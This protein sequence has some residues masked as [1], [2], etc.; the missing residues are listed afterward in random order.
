MSVLSKLK[1]LFHICDHQWVEV[2]RTKVY[3]YFS[4][5]RASGGIPDEVKIV[6]ELRC[7]QC[8]GHKSQEN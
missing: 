1:K 2:N 6:I 5:P 7:S 8:G 3:S 4:D